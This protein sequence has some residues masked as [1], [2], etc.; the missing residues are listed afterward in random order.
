MQNEEKTVVEVVV[1]GVEIVLGLGRLRLLGQT[2]VP[3]LAPDLRRNLPGLLVGVIKKDGA[4]KQSFLY[5]SRF[6][7][8][9]K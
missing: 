3:V 6:Q 4:G 1:V 7:N 2:L 5:Y 9:V 8:S